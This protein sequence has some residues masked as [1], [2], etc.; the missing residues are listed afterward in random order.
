MCNNC[1][2]LNCLKQCIYDAY[3]TRNRAAWKMLFEL[4]RYCTLFIENGVL[5]GNDSAQRDN[6]GCWA[7]TH[8]E[9]GCQRS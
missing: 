7:G 4:W 1:N 6:G 2:V 3:W 5:V 8:V 9:N